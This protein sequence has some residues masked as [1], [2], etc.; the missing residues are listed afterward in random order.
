MSNMSYKR[1][2]FQPDSGLEVYTGHRLKS[3]T[4]QQLMKF[5]DWK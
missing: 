3:E 2:M 5:R 4:H 1:L